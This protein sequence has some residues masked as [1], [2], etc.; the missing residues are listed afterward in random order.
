VLKVRVAAIGDMTDESAG[1]VEECA[2]RG[3]WAGDAKECMRD[4]RYVV[5]CLEWLERTR[6]VMLRERLVSCEVCSI[7][8]LKQRAA[9]KELL[10]SET[11][12]VPQA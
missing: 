4:G 7:C 9:V 1:D 11:R 12:R 3:P 5:V 10:H 2:C 6:F 8:K